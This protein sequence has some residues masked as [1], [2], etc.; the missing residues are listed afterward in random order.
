VSAAESLP[1][2]V[3][4][5]GARENYAIARALHRNCALAQMITDAWAPPGS[6]YAQLGRKLADRYHPDLLGA[7]VFAP[8]FDNLLAESIARARRQTGWTRIMQRNAW[9]ETI[10]GA[11]LKRLSQSQPPGILFAYRYAARGVF[12]TAKSLGW[13]TVLGQIDPGPVE[14]RLVDRLYA[15]AGQTDQRE[16]IPA[17][18]WDLWREELRLADAIV[19]NSDWSRDAL[20]EEGADSQKIHVIPLAYEPTHPPPDPRVA[21]LAFDAQRPLGA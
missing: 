11:R 16:P 20:V 15:E 1:W 6:P 8:T 9:F 12:Q 19:V 14:A 17:R 21:P 18:Y 7:P 4:Q 13:K 5:I 2:V 10:T 3:C